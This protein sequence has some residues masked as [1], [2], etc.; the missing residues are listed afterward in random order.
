MTLLVSDKNIDKPAIW[1]FGKVE[2]KFMKP[3]DPTNVN[4]TY[5]NIQKPKMEYVFA[6]ENTR[7]NYMVYLFLKKASLIF[8]GLIIL[9]ALYFLRFLNNQ[10][11]NIRNLPV[12]S[13]TSALFSFAFLIVIGIIAYVYIL[14]WVKLNILQ[15]LFILSI[16]GIYY[17]FTFSYS[18]IIH[19]L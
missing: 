9:S 8:S 12:K 15:T 1:N 19:R 14:F 17:Y 4:P 5:K 10:G 3:M 13:T 11:I 18:C 16:I 7:S 2:V 6:P